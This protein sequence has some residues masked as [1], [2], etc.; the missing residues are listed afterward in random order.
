MLPFLPKGTDT[1]PAM[2][3]P[4]EIVINA[5][6]QGRIASA[7]V[8]GGGTTTV[9]LEADGR[10]LAELMVPHVPGALKRYRVA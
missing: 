5:A 4:G 8:G 1:V 9:I 10:T 6:Q 3:T 2:L 7:L